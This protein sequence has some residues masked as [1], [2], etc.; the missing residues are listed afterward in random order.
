M[1]MV[2]GA[3]GT[4]GREV[5]QALGREGARFSVL[6]RSTEQ[7]T[8]FEDQ[9][10]TARLGDYRDDASLR[11]AFEG[12]DS[13]FLLTPSSQDQ[14][15]LQARIV[16]SAVTMGVTRIVKLSAL[17]SSPDSPLTIGRQH[18]IAEQALKDSGVG[19]TIL[20]PGS[21]MQNLLFSRESITG[22]GEFY[23]CAG[24]G[25]VPLIDA[26]DIGEVAAICLQSDAHDST[27]YQL[28]GPESLSN[29][30]VA[31]L[32][33][34]SLG[35][36]VSYVDLPAEEYLSGMLQ[37]GM[38][39]WLADDLVMHEKLVSDT[40]QPVSLDCEKILGRPPRSFGVFAQDYAQS[41]FA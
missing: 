22:K 25:A 4:V 36:A 11:A 40:S 27:V 9:E 16:D 10:I 1:I 26:R 14:G 24:N 30:T 39:E 37:S 12:I 15:E 33:S 2:T 19:W 35:V 21:F 31:A 20:Q 17:G 28:T 29:D 18:A 8:H 13:L 23:G 41:F 34:D 3:T 5:C 32:L 6:V 38:P 7:V